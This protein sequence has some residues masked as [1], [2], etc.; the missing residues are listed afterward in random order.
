MVSTALPDQKTVSKRS[1]EE[2]R[3]LQK[4]VKEV[5]KQYR[6]ENPETKIGMTKFSQL[7]PKHVHLFCFCFCIVLRPINS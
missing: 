6:K 5:L 3:I 1:L 4:P 2:P 7:R